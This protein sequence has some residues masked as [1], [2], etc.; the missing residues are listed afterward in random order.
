M[1]SERT[2]ENYFYKRNLLHLQSDGKM[3]LVHHGASFI[4]HIRMWMFWS[5]STGEVGRG[6]GER[7]RVVQWRWDC[8][9]FCTGFMN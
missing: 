9:E 7:T 8:L 4:E 1:S 2:V 6:K 3:S 5:M